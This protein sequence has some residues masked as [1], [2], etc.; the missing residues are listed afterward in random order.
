MK[1]NVFK[2]I[3]TAL[4][5]ECT[6]TTQLEKIHVTD[7]YEHMNRWLANEFGVSVE[8]PSEDN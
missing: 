1:E 4:Y 2:P 7:V 8:F 3:M 6:S 5:P